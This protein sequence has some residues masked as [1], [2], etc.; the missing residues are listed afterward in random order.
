MTSLIIQ[1]R[2][3]DV[4]AWKKTFDSDPLGRAKSGVVGHAIYRPADDP[5][6]VVMTLEFASRAE[7]DAFLARLRVLWGQV[8]AKL[9]FGGPEGVQARILDEIEKV[10]Y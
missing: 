10:E 7:A 2:V 9:G 1:H 8:G 5:N 6:F 3:A 4:D